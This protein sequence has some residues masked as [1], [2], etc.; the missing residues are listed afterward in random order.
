[1]S[2][3]LTEMSAATAAVIAGNPG[4]RGGNLDQQVG[5]VDDL[6]Q[7]GGLADGLLGVVGQPRIDFDGH[8]AVDAVGGF[9]LRTQHVA[10]RPHVVGDDGADRRLGVG[11]AFG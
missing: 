6:P 2:V 5:A 11:A 1:M 10:G 7:L 3:T 9:P 4:R 8:P